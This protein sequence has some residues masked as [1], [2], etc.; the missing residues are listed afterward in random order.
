M[1]VVCL[2]EMG[3][4]TSGQIWVK[5]GSQGELDPRSNIGQ[6]ATTSDLYISR[7]RILF[8]AHAQGQKLGCFYLQA[9][10]S[11]L[12]TFQCVII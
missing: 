1:Y 4:Q 10:N 8:T 7:F 2:S 3:A 6:V 5:L 11:H 9:Y 12:L